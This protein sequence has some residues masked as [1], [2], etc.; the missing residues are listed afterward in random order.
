MIKKIRVE[1]FASI[2]EKVE[3]DFS[4]GGKA[5]EMGGYYSYKTDRKMSLINGFFGANASGK[6]NVLGAI[7][8]VIRLMYTVYNPQNMFPQSGAGGVTLC[9]P[10]AHKNFKDKPTKLGA[11]FLF[12]SNYYTYDLEI[13]GGNEISEE[14]LTYTNLGIKAGKPKV[15]FTRMEDSVV[16]GPDY[17]E[18]E[19]YII[20]I[21]VQ[22][23]QTF[24]SHLI[25]IGAKA[26]SDFIEN[27][28][29]FFLKTDGLDATM[30]SMA[31]IFV[32]AGR[33]ASLEKPKKD[34][35]L[36]LTTEMM[37]CFDDSIE[38]IDIQAEN[39]ISVKVS[40]KNFSQKIDIMQESAGTRE[41]FCHIAEIL[42]IFRKG[43]VVVYDETNRYYHPD[44][45]LSL[46]SIFKNPDFNIKNAQ[47]FFASHNH[48]TF[49]LLELD[50][51]HLVE[52]TGTGSIV[53]KL[54]EIEDLKKRDNL[55]KKYRL[56]ILGA[57]P[58]VVSFDHRLKQVL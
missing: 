52:K 18:Y 5:D 21:K 24:A 47:V 17:K 41:L 32:R 57:V 14:K 40:H 54:S 4:K 50:Q 13:K 29:S 45:E 48:E 35:A 28:E 10:N 12:G 37:N 26:V 53:F 33:L 55:K 49:D 1:N 43:G 42:E 20:N 8:G 56:G 39:S 11:D 16:F 6:S 15:I 38:S 44:V 36:R 22:K 31:M 25:N 51:A 30:P 9:Y 27:R 23:Y 19:T 46:L 34:E 7:V 58:D 3:I 2:G